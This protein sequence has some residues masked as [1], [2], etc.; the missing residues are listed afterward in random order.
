METSS[1]RSA[2]VQAGAAGSHSGLMAVV[3]SL[4][5]STSRAA[6]VQSIL[7]SCPVPCVIWEATDGGA[8]TSE[9]IAGVYQPQKYRPYYPFMLRSGEIGCYLSHRNLWQKMVHENIQRLLVLED[10]IAFLPNFPETLEHAIEHAADGSY[11]QF[12]VRDLSFP[13]YG[14]IDQLQPT[15]IRPRLAPLRTSAQL[16]TLG[17]ARRLLQFSEQFDRP[18]DAAIQMTWEHGAEV[19]VAVPQSVIEVSSSIGGSTIAAQKK[20][21]PLLETIRREWNRARYRQVI[22]K[23]ARQ[24]VQNQRSL[25]SLSNQKIA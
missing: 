10:D 4:R 18:V 25:R 11:V 13:E 24:H 2:S 9:Y 3:I 17:A 20:R 15:L 7:E 1:Q 22:A 12:Q 19:L 14:V 21:R 5:R 16:V 23:C 8:L 6:N